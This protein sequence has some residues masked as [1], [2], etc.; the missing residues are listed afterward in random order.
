MTS[1]LPLLV[2][3]APCGI[4]G[5][6]TAVLGMSREDVFG[7][8]GLILCPTCQKASPSPTYYPFCSESH[9][10]QADRGA[11]AILL[12]CDECDILFARR[13]KEVLQWAR[14]GGQKIFC[15]RSCKGKYLG[16]TYGLGVHPNH[17][18]PKKKS[19]C[20]RG[21]PMEDPNLY[22][23]E[24]SRGTKRSCIAC[25]TIRN[26]GRSKRVPGQCGIGRTHDWAY[27]WQRHSETG[28]GEVRLG[29]L[30]NIPP[31]TIGNVLRYYRRLR[32]ETP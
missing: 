1:T 27:I 11:T 20:L 28:Y 14:R 26:A 3:K 29:R 21:H 12:R 25:K 19:H 22:Y 5:L 13:E 2:V 18:R 24:S 10:K 7:G 16:R 17:A 31:Q 4:A 23:Y 15:N 32:T 9:F 30:L 6:L 8:M